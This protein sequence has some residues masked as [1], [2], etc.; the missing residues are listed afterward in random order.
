[1]SDEHKTEKKKAYNKQK[2]TFFKQTI[3]IKNDFYINKKK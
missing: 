2:K 3:D 1:M